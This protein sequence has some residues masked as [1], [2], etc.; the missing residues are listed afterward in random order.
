MDSNNIS[1]CFHSRCTSLTFRSITCQSPYHS[2]LTSL[3][4]PSF[5][6]LPSLPSP[7][8]PRHWRITS[9]RH[10]KSCHHHQRYIPTPIP[11]SHQHP[12]KPLFLSSFLLN[13][14]YQSAYVLISL[15]PYLFLS[16]SYLPPPSPR[17]P[18]QWQWFQRLWRAQ[19]RGVFRR[20]Y[21]PHQ[22]AVVVIVYVHDIRR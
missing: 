20:P 17:H 3:L 10:A 9:S 5:H 14:P 19:Q 2:P 12:T 18:T 8:L 22:H 13:S 1:S 6:F 16:L 21:G 4:S 11:S 7:P 15:S